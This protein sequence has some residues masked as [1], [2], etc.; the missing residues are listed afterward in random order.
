MLYVIPLHLISPFGFE[1]LNSN[2]PVLELKVR[3]SFDMEA[4]IKLM[5]PKK[6]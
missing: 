2:P 3:V 4:I 5:N 6:N 1:F